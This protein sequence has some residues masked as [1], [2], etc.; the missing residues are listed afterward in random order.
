MGLI[1]VQHVVNQIRNPAV[2]IASISV[3]LFMALFLGGIFFGQDRNGTTVAETFEHFNGLTGSLF[4]MMFNIGF[5]SFE[6]MATFTADRALFNRDTLN[7]AYTESAY[8]LG[9][10]L[11]DILFHHTPAFLFIIVYYWMAGFNPNGAIFAEFLLFAHVVKFASVSYCYL[12]STLI[13]KIEVGNIL[14][15][16]TLVIFMLLSGYFIRDD[17]IPAWIDWLKYVSF[18]RFAYFGVLGNQFP[19]GDTLGK[20]GTPGAVPH[21]QLVASLSV[22]NTNVYFNMGIIMALGCGFRLVAFILLH[23]LYRR[24][25]IE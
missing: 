9:K 17:N 19:T 13:P 16:V 10:N 20:P 5:S 11:A 22:G 3:N 8:F 4:Y 25:G 7:A 23:F 24:V 12:I 18:L 6:S 21:E 14:A 2:I 1:F 15:P